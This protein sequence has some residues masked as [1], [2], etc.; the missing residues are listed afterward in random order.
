MSE[1]PLLPGRSYLLK[2]GART[3]PAS[4]TELKHRI[5][6]NTL[7]KLAAKTLALNEVGLGQ[8]RHDHAGRLR[9]L[10]REPRHRRASS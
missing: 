1:E 6:V 2:I 8:H 9:P 10:R 4:V 3:T 7:D 5:D